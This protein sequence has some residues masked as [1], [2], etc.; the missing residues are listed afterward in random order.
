[1]HFELSAMNPMH[2]EVDGYS[3]LIRDKKALP[4]RTTSRANC[5]SALM[6][7][8]IKTSGLSKRL[9]MEGL[10]TCVMRCGEEIILAPESGRVECTPL[11]NLGRET[12][13]E[14][15]N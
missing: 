2:R 7:R 3:D 10:D 12:L 4:I 6:Y 14:A 11:R 5:N 13:R 9:C 15:H 8:K 1:M